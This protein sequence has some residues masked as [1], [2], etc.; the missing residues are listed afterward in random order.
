[1]NTHDLSHLEE[2]DW[3]AKDGLSNGVRAR[4]VAEVMKAYVEITGKEDAELEEVVEEFLKDFELWLRGQGLVD[5]KRV[6][7]TA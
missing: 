7:F 6:H 3:H 5:S 1:M 2:K 4:T